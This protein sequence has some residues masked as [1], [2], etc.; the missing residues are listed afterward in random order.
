[1]TLYNLELLPINKK[2]SYNRYYD[3]E[4]AEKIIMEYE[5]QKK[6]LGYFYGCYDLCTDYCDYG[7]PDVINVKNIAFIVDDLKLNGINNLSSTII[8]LE[9]PKGKRLKE[10]I[11]DVVFRPS[12]WGFIEKDGRV[13]TERLIGINSFSRHHDTFNDK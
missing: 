7:D 10:S 11:R 2:N 13:I 12:V 3:L 6:R 9:T 5:R 1:M 4:S 8:I